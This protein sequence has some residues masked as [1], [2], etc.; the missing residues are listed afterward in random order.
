MYKGVAHSDSDDSDKS[1]SSDSEYGSDDDRRPKTVRESAAD[2]KTDKKPPKKKSKPSSTSG[3]EKNSNTESSGT[4]TEM[5]Q[6][7]AVSPGSNHQDKTVVKAVVRSPGTR[8]KSRTKEVTKNDVDSDSERELVI[9]LGEDSG[10]KQRKRRRKESA[11]VTALKEPT[12]SRSEGVI[13]GPP[14]RTTELA[15]SRI[16]DELQFVFPYLNSVCLCSAGKGPP[17]GS[18]APSQTPSAPSSTAG[19]KD[20][21]QSPMA[22]PLNVVAVSVVSNGAASS[23]LQNSTP[24]LTPSA[25]ASTAKKQ[26][27]LLPRESV[28]VVQRAVVWNPGTKFQTSSQKWHMQKVQRQQQGQTQTLMQTVSQTQTGSPSVQQ[29]SSTRY[30]TRQTAKGTTYNRRAMLSGVST[31]YYLL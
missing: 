27:P 11:N 1:D 22:V 29:P 16:T 20:P 10:G 7:T 26:R 31:V 15:S 19:L 8:D 18:L 25:P 3:G 23:V 17:A 5:V 14:E 6:K 9:D 24:P 12:T 2:D 21:S 30:Q 28:P 13:T 4:K